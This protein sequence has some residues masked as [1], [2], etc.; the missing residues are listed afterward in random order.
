[1]N[2]GGWREHSRT[3]LAAWVQA[4]VSTVNPRLRV[5]TAR[6]IVAGHWGKPEG[7]SK[8]NLNSGQILRRVRISARPIIDKSVRVQGS[9]LD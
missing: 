4:T 5:F 7:P 1:M 2:N 8:I 6:H 9:G 3:S